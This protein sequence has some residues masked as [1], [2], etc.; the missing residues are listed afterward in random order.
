MVLSPQ[1]RHP[2]L[3]YC[4]FQYSVTKALKKYK[5]DLF[6]SPDGYL[7]LKTTI[8]SVAVIHDINFEHYPKDL[9]WLT[10]N[11]YRRFFP[12]FAQKAKRII[13]VSE[14]SKTDICTTYKIDPTKIDVIYNG[15]GES[16][17]VFSNEENEHTKLKFSKGKPYFLFV[18]ALTPRK[19][20]NRLFL[21]FDE[22]KK[23]NKSDI[24]LLIVGEKYFW[25]QQVENAFS[26]M[27]FKDEVLFTGHL[28]TNE[29]SKIYSAAL[30]LTFISYF[31]GFGLPL[32]EAMKSE[33]PILCANTSASPEIAGKAAIYCNPFK[34][35]SI[36]S[37]LE[38]LAFDLEKRKEII[39]EG[40]TRIKQFNWDNNAKLLWESLMKSINA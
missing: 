2:F 12:R 23:K 3:Q 28:H 30:G 16:F 21:A 11:Y 22:F 26:A 24:K 35:E 19:N 1:A 5:A 25:N 31:E 32:V 9:R 15:V 17:K 29:L 27:E 36:V 39:E 20:L 14:F 7:S 4:W 40:K 8:P 38:T 13:T 18:G 34:H 37:G 10:R 33:I 6:L